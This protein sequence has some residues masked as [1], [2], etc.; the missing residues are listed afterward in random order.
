MAEV[1]HTLLNAGGVPPL[2]VVREAGVELFDGLGFLDAKPFLFEVA[3]EAFYD[4]AVEA[5]ALRDI[6]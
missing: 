2:E 1:T 4:R 3:E 5:R 6:D